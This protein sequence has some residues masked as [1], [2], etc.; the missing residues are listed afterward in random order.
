MPG[1]GISGGASGHGSA[2]SAPHSMT[3]LD[4][5]LELGAPTMELLGK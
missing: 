1:V 5:E 2:E 3:L 4:S